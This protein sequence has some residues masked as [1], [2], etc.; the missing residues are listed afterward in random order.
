ML[1]ATSLAKTQQEAL[2]GKKEN[3]TTPEWYT[4]MTEVHND[5]KLT[6]SNIANANTLLGDDEKKS[7]EKAIVGLF[8]SIKLHPPLS[9]LATRSSKF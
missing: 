3:V 4:N 8:K 1:D 5:S 6:S 2:S 7:A 9:F